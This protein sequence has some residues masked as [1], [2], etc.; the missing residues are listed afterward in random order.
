MKLNIV[1]VEDDP[2]TREI[3][4]F[5]LDL[6]GY[7]VTP[8]ADGERALEHILNHPPDLV[9]LD[10]M[11]PGLNGLDIARTL[12]SEPHTAKIPIL[13]L[14]AR[15]AE[16]DIV[17]G[18]ERGADDYL[19][20]PFGIRELLARIQA[21][22][23][24]VGKLEE[25]LLRFRDLEIHFSDH[26]AFSGTQQLHLTPKEFRLLQALYEARGRVLSRDDLLSTAWGYDYFGDTRTVDVHVRRL[27]AKLGDNQDL[28]QT[29]KGFGY[30]LHE[31]AFREEQAE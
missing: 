26:R 2:D 8:F 28:V 4:R 31:D 3:L 15:S 19:T 18:F 17:R 13:M 9:V 10:L 21:L 24:R 25:K 23:R 22:L 27:R 6:E 20:K 29:V 30:R 11:L 12:R 16:E 1:V 5:N 7:Q 14:T